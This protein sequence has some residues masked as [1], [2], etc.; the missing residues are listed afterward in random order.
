MTPRQ[1]KENVKGTVPFMFGPDSAD[2]RMTSS[3]PKGN[4]K[5]TVPFMFA[6]AYG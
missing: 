3:R 1:P 6:G 5:G 4:V 2:P